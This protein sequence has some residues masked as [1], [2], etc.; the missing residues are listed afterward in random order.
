[1]R[2]TILLDGARHELVVRTSGST[3]HVDA[4]GT[5]IEG[6]RRWD[7]ARLALELAGDGRRIEAQVTRGAGGR[8]ELWLDSER[9]LRASPGP[10]CAGRRRPARARAARRPSDACPRSWCRRRRRG[11][12]RR[13]RARRAR[14]ALRR[15]GSSCARASPPRPGGNRRAMSTGS[16]HRDLRGPPRYRSPACPRAWRKARAAARSASDPRLLAAAGLAALEGAVATRGDAGANGNGADH[17]GPGSAG[18]W[19]A[20]AGFRLGEED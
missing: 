8:I 12:C 15:G 3:F 5:T 14:G 18:P 17:E 1:M 16:P 4:G 9:P 6:T 7:G 10:R 20:L 19:T 13:R 2:K 11:T